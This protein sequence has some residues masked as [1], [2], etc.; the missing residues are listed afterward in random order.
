MQAHKDA[1]L[2]C[3]TLLVPTGCRKEF[4]D[5]MNDEPGCAFFVF[6]EALKVPVQER[7]AFLDRTCG[8]DENLRREVERLLITY[9]HLGDFLEEPGGGPS[10]E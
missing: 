4:R 7:S 10:F 8:D 9:D 1:N 2:K 6:T 3:L 5:S